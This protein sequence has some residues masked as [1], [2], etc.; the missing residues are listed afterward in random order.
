MVALYPAGWTPSRPRP[1]NSGCGQGSWRESALEREGEATG[2][3]AAQSDGLDE[4]SLRDQP[5]DLGTGKPAAPPRPDAPAAPGPGPRSGPRCGWVAQRLEGVCVEDRVQ[6]T[7]QIVVGRSADFQAAAA[8]L[9]LPRG[10][11]RLDQLP[12]GIG[13]I[14]R[15]SAAFRHDSGLPSRPRR[16]DR[17]PKHTARN[18]APWDETGGGRARR[19]P[20]SHFHIMN[21][22]NRSSLERPQAH[23]SSKAAIKRYTPSWSMYRKCCHASEL[24][25]EG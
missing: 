12:P 21:H 10:Q 13:Q 11:D 5:L 19:L 16:A 6:Q 8:A 3:D 22:T 14:A 18:P 24:C 23:T 1:V 4:T 2:Q 9:G 25:G 17:R 7:A 20:G 15:V